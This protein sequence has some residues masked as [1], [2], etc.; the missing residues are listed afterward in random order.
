MREPADRPITVLIVQD[1]VWMRT[2]LSDLLPRE[3]YVIDQAANGWQ[4][5]RRA[6][7]ASSRPM[8]CY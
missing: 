3:G 6:A 8:L 7:P 5:I 2:L 1:D 4:G